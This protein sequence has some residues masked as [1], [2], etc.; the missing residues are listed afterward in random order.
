[1]AIEPVALLEQE[2][3]TGRALGARPFVVSFR[4]AYGF[5]AFAA[6][7]NPYPYRLLG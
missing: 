6:L 7:T 5:D 1:V 3:R 4:L 2:K